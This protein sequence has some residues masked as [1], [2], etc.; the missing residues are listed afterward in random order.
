MIPPAFVR[1]IKGVVDTIRS[2]Q[3]GFGAIEV[4]QNPVFLKP[5]NVTDFPDRRLKK[6]GGSAKHLSIRQPF[7]QFEFDG[8]G[9]AK[10]VD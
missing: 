10:R 7:Q 2:R 1:N 4:T 8:A 5:A 3:E 6:V 9:I